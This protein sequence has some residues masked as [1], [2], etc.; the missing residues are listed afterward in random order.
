[1]TMKAMLWQAL[2]V[3]MATTGFLLM[4]GLVDAQEK[5]KFLFKSPPEGQLQYTQRHVLDV[6]DVAGHQLRLVEMHV[7]FT[8]E[9][10]IIGGLKVVEASQWLQGDQVNGN[11]RSWGYQMRLMEN[12]DKIFLRQENLLQVAPDGAKAS[13]TTVNTLIGGTGKFKGIRGTLKTTGFTNLKTGLSTEAV[14]EG[15]Y[16]IEN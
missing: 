16:W 11:G 10:L 7:K 8:N 9:A 2:K 15:E 1:M 13:F 14:W 5:Q 12:G 3:L 6:G 4:V